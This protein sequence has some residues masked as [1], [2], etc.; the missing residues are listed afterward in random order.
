[1]S[2]SPTPAGQPFD[3]FAGMAAMN[4]TT[5][6][7]TPPDGGYEPPVEDTTKASQSAETAKEDDEDDLVVGQQLDSVPAPSQAS[8]PQDSGSQTSTASSNAAPA[9]E[10]GAAAENDAG[11][12]AD[13]QQEEAHGSHGPN[14]GQI[15]P[16]MLAAAA[17]AEKAGQRQGGGGGGGPG[18][19]GLIAGA[20]TGTVGLIGGGFKMLGNGVKALNRTDASLPKRK[21]VGEMIATRDPVKAETYYE[22][23]G[24]RVV[25]EKIYRDAFTGM[26]S[27]IS[28][29]KAAERLFQEGVGEM[30]EVLEN[31][32]VKALADAAGT[33]IG[34]FIHS[35]K[36][37]TVSD[38]ASKAVVQTLEQ[39]SEF[40]A[41]EDKIVSAGSTFAEKKDAALAKMATIE[42]SFPDRANTSIKKQQLSDL[43][44]GMKGDDVSKASAKV[45]KIMDEIEAMAN[46]LKEAIRK[47]IDKVASIFQ[48]K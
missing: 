14:G 36:S 13:Q 37:G 40:K 47:A 18:L 39:S 5:A 7:E 33:S 17:A 41:A 31:S 2:T 43:A 46:A 48:P 26:N 19:S 44:D 3:P 28:E 25:A 16:R 35:V 15:D 22:N 23:A 9:G 1:M 8:A 27:A 10:T 30:R 42:T 29:A 4:S 24:D 32:D 21:T 6:S 45:K 20:A 34:D 38:A 12:D 11:T